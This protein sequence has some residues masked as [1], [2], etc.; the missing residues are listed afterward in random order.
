MAITQTYVMLRNTESV[1][2]CWDLTTI[3]AEQELGSM[4]NA[5]IGNVV[6]FISTN[7]TRTCP[8]GCNVTLLDQEGVTT[9]DIK[10]V[11]RHNNE[12][13][14]SDITN[15]GTV[16]WSFGKLTDSNLS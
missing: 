13:S 2:E 8:H 6:D 12:G 14:S 15:C 10:I 3:D 4:D 1:G 11:R 5:T 9:Y 16:T 7:G